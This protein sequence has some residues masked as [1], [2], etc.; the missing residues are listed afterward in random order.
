MSLT[1]A[2]FLSRY[3][4]S[5]TFRPGEDKFFESVLGAF[6]LHVDAVEQEAGAQPFSLFPS[7]RVLSLTYLYRRVLSSGRP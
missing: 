5:Q 6:K 4:E 3:V 7:T 2:Q 1:P